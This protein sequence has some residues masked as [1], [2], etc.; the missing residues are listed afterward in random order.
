MNWAQRIIE[1]QKRLV[2]DATLPDGIGVL[3]PLKGPNA[4]VIARTMDLFYNKYLHSQ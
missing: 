1:F 4:Q 3:D 2:M